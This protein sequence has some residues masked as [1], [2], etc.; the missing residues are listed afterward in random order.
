MTRLKEFIAKIAGRTPGAIS[1]FGLLI[2]GS[3]LFAFGAQFSARFVD[4]LI[5]LFIYIAGATAWNLV[6]G[7]GGQFS[8]VHAAFV[9]AG[10]YTA[11][12]VTREPL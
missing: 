8:L 1:W 2:G 5:W 11:I 12:M 10:S 3:L 4:V 6:G 9:G 7:F